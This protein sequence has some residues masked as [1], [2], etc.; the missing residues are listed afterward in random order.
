MAW[1]QQDGEA[2]QIEIYK[3][4]QIQELCERK[5][6]VVSK[7]SA[8]R[9]K[10]EQAC[11]AKNMFKGPKTIIKN[12]SDE[13]VKEMRCELDQ[14]D[15]AYVA[16]EL[17]FRDGEK[18]K[19]DHRNMGKKGILR[20]VQALRAGLRERDVIK[21]FEAVGIRNDVRGCGYGYNMDTIIKN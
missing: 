16:H 11:D 18:M 6:I 21:S 4:P 9:T 8:S 15:K 10:L 12:I 19:A 20:V 3:D 13:D 7:F 1:Y 17:Q 14:L 2:E 5:R